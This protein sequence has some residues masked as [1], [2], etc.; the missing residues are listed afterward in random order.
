MKRVF[1]PNDWQSRERKGWENSMN[2]IRKQ[3][4]MKM[5]QAGQ[6]FLRGKFKIR[7][8]GGSEFDVVAKTLLLR[9]AIGN[10]VRP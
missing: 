2:A 3:P 10:T 9:Q 1:E 6:S 4:K 8:Q 7:N 5:E